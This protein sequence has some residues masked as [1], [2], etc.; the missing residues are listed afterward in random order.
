LGKSAV[1]R[2]WTERAVVH[3][4]VGYAV[5]ASLF[6]RGRE[7]NAVYRSSFVLGLSL[8]ACS[9][10]GP[11]SYRHVDSAVGY[12]DELGAPRNVQYY[13]HAEPERELL[14]LTV[15]EKAE[16]DK[17]RM[18]VV[19]RVE[20]ALRGDKVVSRE[21]AKTIQ[22]FD[23]KAGVASCNERFARNVWVGL[24]VNEQTYR[25][26]MPSVRGE[27]V[28]N[29][30]GELRDALFAETAPKEATLV[31]NGVDSGSV[32]LAGLNSQESRLNAVLGEFRD[33]LAKDELTKADITRSY[34][35]YDSLVQLDTGGDPRVSGAR[36]RFLELLYQ[37]KQREATDTMKRNLQALSEAK[38]LIPSI[39]PGLVPPYFL[40]AIQGGLVSAEALG[41]AR[42]EA[43]LTV[44]RHPELCTGPFTWGRITPAQYPAVT[45]AAFSYLRFAYEDPFT[46]EVRTLCSR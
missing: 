42:G 1:Y 25:L 30:A 6:D 33:L 37:R 32:S 4:V 40:S 5:A 39:G 34:E 29:L 18:K 12:T 21:P 13:A 9:G 31:V 17:L 20:E 36:A 38:G 41:W 28:A 22:E 23:S 14:R 10:G 24:K 43:A 11:I 27:V 44:H 35:L 26:G 19:S 8:A 46:A 45:R 16:C 2:S 3:T 7:V 15:F